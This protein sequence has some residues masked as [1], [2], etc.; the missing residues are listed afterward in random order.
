M[1]EEEGCCGLDCVFFF[2]ALPWFVVVAGGATVEVAVAVA[3]AVA[4]D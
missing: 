2:P 1:A 4:M 3:V